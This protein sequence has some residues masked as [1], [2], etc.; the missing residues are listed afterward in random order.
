[1]KARVEKVTTALTVIDVGVNV[2]NVTEE[3]DAVHTRVLDGLTHQPALIPSERV[4]MPG[5]LLTCQVPIHT[6]LETGRLL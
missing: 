3:R 6:R 2:K 4:R 1:M 5:L